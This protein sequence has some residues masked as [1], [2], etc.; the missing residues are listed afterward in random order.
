MWGKLTERNNRTKTRMISD[1]HELY[2]FLA[3]PGIEVVSLLFATDTVVRCS[4][5][6]MEEEN[7]PHLKQTN[8][9]IVAYVTTGARIHLYKYLDKLQ[10][11]AIT[12][13]RIA[14][15]LYRR[16]VNLL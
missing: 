10:E 7:I 15:C 3:T 9:V 13:T 11:N 5:K 14:L 8:E 2:R 6:Y 12:Q 16:K 1:P 4:W